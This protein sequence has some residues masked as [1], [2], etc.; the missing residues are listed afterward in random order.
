MPGDPFYASKAWQRLRT[1]TLKAANGRCAVPRCPLPAK[2]V[3]HIRSRRERP[4]L[5]LDATN[6]EPL[7][8][9]HHDAHTGRRDGGFGNPVRPGQAA[10]H[11]GCDE[12]GMPRD[13]GH[14]WN[15][16]KARG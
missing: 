6:L 16:S 4:D 2:H 15:A 1:I 12:H 8:K 10:A 11:H 3:N 14:P 5:E 9:T 7:C 13:P